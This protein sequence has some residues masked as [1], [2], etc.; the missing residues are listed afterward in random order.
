MSPGILVARA[1]VENPNE[2]KCITYLDGDYSNV[3]FTN[4]KWTKFNNRTDD[5]LRRVNYESKVK[6]SNQLKLLT[7]K[8]EIAKRFEKALKE[9]TEQE[10]IYSEIKELCRK[11]VWCKW[12]GRSICFKEEAISFIIEEIS[13]SISRGHVI[14]SFENFINLYMSKF[15]KKYKEQIKTVEFDERRM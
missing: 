6:K 10:F 13:D 11:I 12:K 1:F 5:V 2:Y 14:I 7:E 9:G 15:Y 3:M 8:I 4:I